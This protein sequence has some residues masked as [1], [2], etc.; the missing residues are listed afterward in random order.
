MK[1]KSIVELKCSSPLLLIKTYKTYGF[2][3][4][5]LASNFSSIAEKLYKC[6]IQKKDI[7]MLNK[8]TSEYGLL[9]D[10]YKTF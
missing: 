3:S 1:I 6:E 10:D 2:H 8:I 4:N 7:E 5:M 9:S